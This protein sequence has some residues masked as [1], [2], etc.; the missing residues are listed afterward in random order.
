MEGRTVL[1]GVKKMKK[2]TDLEY[3]DKLQI[4]SWFDDLLDE[5]KG[6]N[7]N[8]EYNDC[9]YREG[10]RDALDGFHDYVV[11]NLLHGGD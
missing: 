9:A 8:Q 3:Q 2:I 4:L 11:Y 7:L 6:T 5:Y 10:V 1:K